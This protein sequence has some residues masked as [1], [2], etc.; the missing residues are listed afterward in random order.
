MGRQ[1]RETVWAYEQVT[2]LD[3]R[4]Y[5]CAV[6]IF[7]DRAP[8]DE[9]EVYQRRGKSPFYATRDALIRDLS[10]DGLDLE[11]EPCVLDIDYA[12]CSVGA[13]LS[14]DRIEATL[15]AWNWFE[16]VM[17][18]LGMPFAFRGKIANKCYDKLFYG[19][20][21]PSV[22]PPGEH[23]VPMWRRKE[24]RK[25][26]QVMRCGAARLRSHLSDAVPRD[27]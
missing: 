19:L 4:S 2:V 7:S 1:K 6:L 3:G 12:I 14:P 26:A 25:I 5:Y 24:G 10:E 15:N 22:T 16:D 11:P 13:V 18:I 9:E 21:L 23:Y 8:E 17:P 27:E 20:N